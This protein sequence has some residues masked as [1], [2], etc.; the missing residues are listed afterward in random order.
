M[1][2]ELPPP[3]IDGQGSFRTQL[4][5]SAC[6]LVVAVAA[7]AAFGGWQA[8]HER[9]APSRSVAAQDQARM[10]T[11]SRPHQLTAERE[12]PVVFL[13]GSDAQADRLLAAMSGVDA[14]RDSQGFDPL[15]A[16]VVVTSSS[17]SVGEAL[18]MSSA[19]VIQSTDGEPEFRVIDLRKP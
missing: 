4:L 7:F 6:S 17:Q 2:P 1:S 5:L 11:Q 19:E 9:S 13:A 8:E 14:I 16:M 15:T 10:T 18:S 3:E 12:R